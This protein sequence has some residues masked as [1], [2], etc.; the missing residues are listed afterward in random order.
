[1]AG[2]TLYTQQDI[3]DARQKM[4]DHLAS[5]SGGQVILGCCTQGCCE[6]TAQS[7]T[8]SLSGDSGKGHGSAPNDRQ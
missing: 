1:M 8:V 3:E 6:V 7:F 5:L 4:L 2:K